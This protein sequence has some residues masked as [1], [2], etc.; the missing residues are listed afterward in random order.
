[1]NVFL[2]LVHIDWEASVLSIICPLRQKYNTLGQDNP[3]SE[4]LLSL[5]LISFSFF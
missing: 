4:G 1:M 2:G 5:S 3:G